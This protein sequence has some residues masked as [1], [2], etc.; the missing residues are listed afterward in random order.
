M[1][2]HHGS[3]LGSIAQVL[4]EAID[5]NA[6]KA[7]RPEPVDVAALRKKLG[8]THMGFAAKF[9]ISGAHWTRGDDVVAKE[10]QAV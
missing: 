4:Q 9:C 6:A 10:L 5:L 1:E 7:H 2:K 3:F 8:M